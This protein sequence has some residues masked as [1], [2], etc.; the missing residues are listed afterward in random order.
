MNILPSW[1]RVGMNIA[2][3]GM[4]HSDIRLITVDYEEGRRF[5]KIKNYL[6][7][8]AITE[9]HEDMEYLITELWS[10]CG[11]YFDEAD[12]ECIYSNHSSMELNQIN[13]AVFRRKELISQA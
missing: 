8:E 10:V 2:M 1:L 11:E 4:I 9:D 5:L 3:L 7:R 12:F 13:G 6:S